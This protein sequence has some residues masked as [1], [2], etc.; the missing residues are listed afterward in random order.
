[1]HKL[2]SRL[3]RHFKMTGEV[4]TETPVI[5][6]T[7]KTDKELIAEEEKAEKVEVEKEAETNEEE[8]KKEKK[9]KEK[10]VNFFSRLRRH[11]KMTGEVEGETPVITETEKTDKEVIAEEEKAKEEKTEQVEVEKEAET[12]EE[13]E[14]KVKE[15]KVKEKKPT[16]FKKDWEEDKVYLYQSN[17]THQIPSI[18]AQEL[19]IETFFKLHGIPYENVS[20]NIKNVQFPYVEVNGVE[21]GY[22]DILTKLADKFEKNLTAHLTPEQINVEHAMIKMVENHLYW[23]TM[24]WKTEHPD[25]TV[26]GYKINLPTYLDSKLPLPILNLHYKMNVCKKTQKRTKGQGFHDLLGHAKSDMKVLSDTLGDKEFMF[27]AEPS[28]LDLTVFSV[29]AQL[30]AVEEGVACPL[31]DHMTEHHTN[32]AGLVARMKDRAWSEHWDLA[33]GETMDLNPHIPK[34]EPEEKKEEEA[35][36]KAEEEEKKD[37]EKKEETETKEEKKEEKE[38]EKKD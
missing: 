6:E 5:T 29:L 20:H 15:K 7:E 13:E 18:E 27:G 38:E 24:D 25:N 17:R 16:V 10:K 32:L 2:L 4:E 33:T 37:E 12:K 9:V 14:K 26:K 23:A 30:T 31:R 28:L 21:I 11:I 34:P 19:K 36:A 3:R 8:K 22:T 1:V 35:E